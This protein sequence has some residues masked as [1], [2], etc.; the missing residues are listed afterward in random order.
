MEKVSGRKC[1]KR[2][3][4]TLE[5][6]GLFSGEKNPKDII[7]LY[8][9]WIGDLPEIDLDGQLPNCSMCDLWENRYKVV[10]GAGNHIADVMFVGEAPGYHEDRRG[11]PFVGKSGKLLRNEWLPKLE[12][13]PSEV[14]IT[15]VCKCAPKDEGGKIGKPTDEQIAV[16]LMWLEKEIEFVSPK[17]IVA[18]GSYALKALSNENYISRMNGKTFEVVTSY[19]GERG[20]I[21]GYALYH[22]AAILWSG[23]KLSVNNELE[24]LKEMINEL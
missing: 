7:E 10:C 2:V 14:Y 5:R 3:V 16:C 23:E 15:N 17:I 1:N 11:I 21:I 12:L 8:G 24:V 22:P 13:T 19:L 4:E 18:L 20:D 9:C 6:V